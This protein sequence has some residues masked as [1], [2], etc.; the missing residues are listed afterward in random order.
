MANKKKD[1]GAAFDSLEP[2]QIDNENPVNNIISEPP[3]KKDPDLL[4]GYGIART[5]TKSKRVQMNFTPS[6]WRVMKDRANAAGLS[7]N[8][9][10]LQL[11]EKE[12]RR[13]QKQ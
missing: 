9:Y 1:F 8:E 3:A 4:P 10:I 12:L 6:L 7:F 5:E 11:C 2:P 13:E